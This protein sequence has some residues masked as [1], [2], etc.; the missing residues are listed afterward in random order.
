MN[1]LLRPLD[2]VNDVTWSIVIMCILVEIMAGIS[3][4]YI[5]RLAFDEKRMSDRG[6][7]IEDLEQELRILN[8]FREFGRARVLRS[9]IDYEIAKKE[10][11]GQAGK[12]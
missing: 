5:L 11:H 9:M 12:D 3:I 6:V 4:A 7:T 2:N 8:E 10:R 1:L